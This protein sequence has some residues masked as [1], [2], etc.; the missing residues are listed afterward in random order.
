MDTKVV[1]RSVLGDSNPWPGEP[2]I[3]RIFVRD[4]SSA[5]YGNGV[6][7]GMADVIHDRL[8]EKIDWNPT[9]INSLTASTPAAIRTPIHFSTD[10]ECLER[11]APTVGKVELA[12]VTY[13]WIRNSLELGFLKLSENLRDQISRNPMLEIVGAAEQMGF[14]GEGNLAGLVGQEEKAGAFSH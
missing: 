9:W 7:L 14:D 4:L 5:T 12:E 6:G 10:R 11:M 8:L 2:R 3:E 13:G 1:N